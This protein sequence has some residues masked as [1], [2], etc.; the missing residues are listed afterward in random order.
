MKTDWGPL[1]IYSGRRRPPFKRAITIAAPGSSGHEFS[2][3]C[4][5][6]NI[7][8]LA[9]D[10]SSQIPSGR[11]DSKTGLGGRGKRKESIGLA[12]DLYNRRKMKALA[13]LKEAE[14]PMKTRRNK[15]GR[16]TFSDPPSKEPSPIPPAKISDFERDP[17]RLESTPVR[18]ADEPLSVRSGRKPQLTT[19]EHPTACCVP[20]CADATIFITKHSVIRRSAQPD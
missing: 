17:S 5:G 9:S 20:A 7:N 15:G 6:N 18:N 1:L 14:L 19:D 11:R 10:F 2:V 12:S 4:S 8:H 16:V 13:K 3:V